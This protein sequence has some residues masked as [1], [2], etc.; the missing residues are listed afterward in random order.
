MNYGRSII[1]CKSIWY[2]AKMKEIT[3]FQQ[4]EMSSL[5]AMMKLKRASMKYDTR[6]YS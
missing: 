3:N 6:E 4:K 1:R 2:D 5:Q